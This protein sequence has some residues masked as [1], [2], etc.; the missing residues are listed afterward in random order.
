MVKEDLVKFDGLPLFPERRATTVNYTL[1]ADEA[2]LYAEVTDYVRAE[3]NRADA[4]SNDHAR[5]NVGFA[6]T[7][8]QRRLASSPEAIY[9]SLRR[10]RERLESRLREEQLLQ[11]GGSLGAVQ[12]A[13]VDWDD[14]DEAP[15]DEV[16]AQEQAVVDQASA[17]RTISELRLEILRLVELEALAQQL[18]YSGTDRKW[19]QLRELLQDQS[20][21]YGADGQRLKL[22]IFTEHRDTLDYLVRRV[23][24]LLGAPERVVAIHGGIQRDERRKAQANFTQNKEVQ[25]L[26]ATD[27]AGEGVNLQRAHLMVNY[28][29]PWNPNRLEQ[30]FGRIHRIGQTEVCHVWNLVAA[31]TREGD[32]YNRLLIKLEQ[33]RQALGGRVFDVLG[34]VRFE[35]RSLRDLLME[36]I[37]YGDSPEVRDRLHQQVDV[38][39]DSSHIR[40]LLGGYALAQD[41]MDTTKAQAIRA[42]MERADARRLQPHFVASFFQ[43]AF[44]LL[45]GRM[46]QREP[47]RY[48]VTYVPSAIRDRDRQIGSGWPVLKTYERVTFDKAL[49]VQ[50]G[51]PEA[52]FLY[53]GSPLLDAVIDLTLERH[54]T[55]LKLGTV[56]VDTAASPDQ[57]RVLLFLE[58]AI[59][60]GRPRQEG[61]RVV[62][63]RELQFVELKPDGSA[64]DAGG[65]PYLDYRPLTPDELPLVQPLL[66]QPWLQGDLEEKALR[67]AA[68]EMVPKHL[69]RVR[70]RVEAQVDKTRQAVHQRLTTEV[71]YW[72]HRAAVLERQE[73][74]GHTPRL[75]SAGARRRRDDLAA[76]LDKRQ[77]ELAQ[78]RQLSVTPPR[79]IG[80][81]LVVPLALLVAHPDATPDDHASTAAERSRIE[82]LAMQAVMRAERLEG[83]EPVDVSAAKVGYDIESRTAGSGKLRFV[84]VKGRAAGATTV[85]VTKNEILTA[86]NKPEDW[87]LAIVEVDAATASTPR[88]FRRPFQREPDFAATSVTFEV[89]KLG[90]G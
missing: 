72:D 4:L 78:E 42:D 66:G 86:L 3:F 61:G 24:T 16:M 32:V 11:R 5:S 34:K 88:Y 59:S 14:L 70:E 67:Y 40:E 46:H 8:L 54:R 31:E 48:E 63:S 7:V 60:N 69:A 13:S 33:E 77:A 58:H 23:S 44:A 41:S 71:L 27:A 12:P 52:E 28:D 38:A 9:Q 15:D 90:Y 85:T 10:R 49:V 84:E 35:N 64:I 53:P 76:R 79:L 57:V 87:W 56:L 1:S 50:E 75:N 74:V 73:E 26:I 19:E 80:A 68:Q 55:L 82:Q 65:A 30:R 22:I 25:V 29:L 36:A 39:L 37:R 43:Q 45:G 47:G 89:V 62:V 51:K 17:A 83:Y 2:H 18:V 6:L 21:M 20:A 81:A